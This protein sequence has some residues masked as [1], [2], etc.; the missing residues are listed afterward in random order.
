MGKITTTWAVVLVVIATFSASGQSFQVDKV[1]SK[2]DDR[3][4]KVLNSLLPRTS[5]ADAV[6]RPYDL[7]ERMAEYGVSGVSIAVLH[8]GQ[9]DWAQGYGEVRAG[10][11]TAV[12]P[13]TLFQAASISKSLTAMVALHLADDDRCDRSRLPG[14]DGAAP[15]ASAGHD[16]EHV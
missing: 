2:A 16:T 14:A 13:T 1:R 4:A 15:P 3:A 8:H 5:V 9:I 6:S 10:S 7:E 12:T 11:G